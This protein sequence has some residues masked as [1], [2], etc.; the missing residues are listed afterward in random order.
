VNLYRDT[1]VNEQWI[2]TDDQTRNYIGICKWKNQVSPDWYVF[3]M[4]FLANRT[5]IWKRTVLRPRGFKG[6][7]IVWSVHI[8]AKIHSNCTQTKNGQ[9]WKHHMIYPMTFHQSNLYSYT[10]CFIQRFVVSELK[11]QSWAAIKRC[12]GNT[13]GVGTGDDGAIATRYA[14]LCREMAIEM[15]R[16]PP[17]IYELHLKFM[18]LWL[19]SIQMIGSCTKLQSK[20]HLV[21]HTVPLCLGIWVS[22]YYYMPLWLPLLTKT[23]SWTLKAICMFTHLLR[24]VRKRSCSI[25]DCKRKVHGKIYEMTQ[26]G[27]VHTALNMVVTT[28]PID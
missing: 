6:S 20:L 28:L 9:V 16:D 21:V 8:W 22:R 5:V 24:S 12:Y 2:C 26:F 27:H 11:C 3:I 15:L 19:S 4:D 14:H 1:A 23:L 17:A 7:E 10:P 25:S 13:A 18:Q